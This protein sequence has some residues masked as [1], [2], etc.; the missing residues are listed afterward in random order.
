M[1]PAGFFWPSG[2]KRRNSRVSKSPVV[3]A[4]IGIGG[5]VALSL[6]M[7]TALNIRHEQER[8]PLEHRLETHFGRRLTAPVRVSTEERDGKSRLVVE[9]CVIA[10]LRKDRIVETAGRL[11]WASRLGGDCGSGRGR[12]R[13]HR[14]WP[15]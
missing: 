6:M 1:P 8:D 7:R 11:A 9:L 13:S 2:R 3:I 12:H 15:G 4:V 5:C 14:R 10:G